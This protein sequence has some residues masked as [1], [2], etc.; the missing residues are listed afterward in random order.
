MTLSQ[1]KEKL[2]QLKLPGFID[3]MNE[4]FTHPKAPTLTI[5][6]AMALMVDKELLIRQQ[7]R[8]NR[9][10]KIAKLRY[11]NACVESI[12]YQQARKLNQQKLKQLALGDWVQ[13]QHNV[14][15][16]GPTGVGKTYIACALADKVC[17]LNYSVRYFRVARLVELLRMAHADGSY[18]RFLAQLAKTNLLVLDDWGIDKLSRQTR[19]D[20]LE[21]LEDRSGLQSTLITTQL[22]SECWHQ[23]IGDSTIADAICD[24][25]LHQAYVISI[26]GESMRK[27]NKS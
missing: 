17:R 16:M 4:L 15:L 19:Q 10:H 7:R 24:R 27:P 8:L 13:Q 9:L 1:T 12:D 5:D 21:I 14:V 11:P 2:A 3:V 20:L 26:E 25:L 23:Y 6:E 18:H 22:P